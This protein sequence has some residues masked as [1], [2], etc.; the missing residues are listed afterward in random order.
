[1]SSVV[2]I[3]VRAICRCSKKCF[4]QKMARFGSPGWI[5]M[6]QPPFNSSCVALQ[7]AL[8]KVFA[9]RELEVPVRF[10][11]HMDTEVEGE[12]SGGVCNLCTNIGRVGYL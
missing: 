7:Y 9:N 10:N 1:M 8:L 11:V 2:N 6:I 5:P 3:L 4:A 12:A